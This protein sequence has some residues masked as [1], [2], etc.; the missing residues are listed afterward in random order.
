VVT[1]TQVAVTEVMEAL[2]LFRKMVQQI[3]GTAG[4]LAVPQK[5]A[6]LVV[7][8]LWSSVTTERRKDVKK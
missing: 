2:A 5:Q 3:P 7:A 6:M 8:A 1:C 4:R